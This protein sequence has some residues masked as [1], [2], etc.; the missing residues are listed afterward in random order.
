MVRY[1]REYWF[2]IT[3]FF[4]QDEENLDKATCSSDIDDAEKDKIISTFFES[5][6][7]A[8]KFLMELKESRGLPRQV[9]NM[10]PP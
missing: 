1:D 10:L 3:S 6:A 9:E 2:D 7:D 8:I 5:Q 4:G